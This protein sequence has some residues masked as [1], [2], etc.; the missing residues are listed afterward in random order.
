MTSRI[1]PPRQRHTPARRL[2][3]HTTRCF[4]RVYRHDAAPIDLVGHVEHGHNVGA[5]TIINASTAKNLG[6][7]AGTF[8]LTLRVLA[9][10]FNIPA[11]IKVGD[12]IS[13][14]WQRGGEKFHG[15]LGNIDG[16]RRVRTV[17]ADGATSEEFAITG[18]DVGKVFET[19]EV[20]FNEYVRFGSNV[21][22]RIFGDRLNYIPGGTPDKVVENLV[23]AFLGSDG[24]VGGAWRWPRGLDALGQYVV[25]GMKLR[26]A[27]TKEPRP[28]TITIGDGIILPQ[29]S[30]LLRGELFDEN[31]LFQ[32]D[33][34]TKLHDML[35]RWSNPILNELFYDIYVE[36]DRESP[37]DRPKPMIYLRERPF[38]NGDDGI[39][40]PWFR[41][42]RT[43]VVNR[44]EVYSDD[45]GSNDAERVNLIMLYARSSTMTQMDQYAAYPPAVDEDDARKYGLRRWERQIDFA[46]VGSAGDNN[47]W[48][49]EIA[50]WERL[51]QSWYGLNHEWL[52]G[53]ANFKFLLAEARVGNRLLIQG[54]DH[55]DVTQA[56]IEGVTH[57]WSFPSGGQTVLSLTRGFTG[58]DA[59][60][61]QRVFAKMS[62]FKR[63][64]LNGVVD[65]AGPAARPSD[66]VDV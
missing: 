25:D 26:I 61:A 41:Q 30:G 16:V 8:N 45:L 6:S 21:G 33:P 22:G 2:S 65:F 51:I 5:P 60:L 34:G 19:A 44:D 12:W 59:S 18:R 27:G 42:L 54:T 15:T 43:I 4:A 31:S 7:A 53:S 35:T 58:D 47:A 38:V 3:T 57:T 52:N 32:P 10:K 48:G 50:R 28:T 17:V 46:G 56:Y 40:S 37:P 36:D 14:W 64:I 9:R 1:V 29:G 23:S 66:E 20:W 11:E 24:N 49:A 63:P 55:D 13:I 39:D 62:R